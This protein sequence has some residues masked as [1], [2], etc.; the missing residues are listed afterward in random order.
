MQLRKQQLELDMEQP[1]PTRPQT[2]A[3]DQG[4]W[5]DP[6]KTAHELRT[7]WLVLTSTAVPKAR[8]EGW[9]RQSEPEGGVVNG[10][11]QQGTRSP[12]VGESPSRSPRSEG[13]AW[14]REA[15]TPGRSTG[16][17]T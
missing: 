17:S 7:V 11:S 12:E 5:Q 16:E 3:P 6:S 2:P 13:A 9:E 10:G 1:T 4:Q 15:A 14:P 8:T